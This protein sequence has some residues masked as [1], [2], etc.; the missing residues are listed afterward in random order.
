[1]LKAHKLFHLSLLASGL[2]VAT[3]CHERP[4]DSAKQRL[5]PVTIKVTGPPGYR[6]L[7]SATFQK[8]LRE[9]GVPDSLPP[10]TIKV[11]GPPGFRQGDPASFKAIMQGDAEPDT[12]R[13]KNRASNPQPRIIYPK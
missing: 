9:S 3:A 13:L 2:L 8:L 5:P 7:D 1:M 4:S 6:Q 10:V 12:S 11:T